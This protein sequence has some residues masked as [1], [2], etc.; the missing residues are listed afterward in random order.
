LALLTSRLMLCVSL[1][2]GS[3]LYLTSLEARVGLPIARN[4]PAPEDAGYST[5]GTKKLDRATSVRK[6][7][8]TC[9]DGVKMV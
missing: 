5:T 4:V 9:T 6:H 3:E 2:H 1:V 7:I 8:P